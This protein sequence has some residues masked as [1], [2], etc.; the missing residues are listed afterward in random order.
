MPYSYCNWD[1]MQLNRHYQPAPDDTCLLVVSTR[2]Y[3]D[4]LKEF[5]D[6][7]YDTTASLHY[8]A[9]YFRGNAWTAVPYSNLESLL[10]LKPSLRNLVIFTE[11]LGKTYTSGVNRA[12]M[13]MRLYHID[14]IF[15]DWPTQRPYMSRGKNFKTTYQVSGE[16]AKPYATFLGE[17]QRYKDSHAPKFQSITIMFHSMGNLILMHGLRSGLFSNIHPGFAD[18]VILNAACVPQKRHAQWLSKLQF[19]KEIFVTINDRD[20]NL[21]GARLILLRHVMGETTKKP[22]LPGIHYVDFS[23]VLNR[24]HNYYLIIPLLRQKPFLKQFYTDVFSGKMPVLTY[25]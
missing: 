15:F 25:P 8:F 6:Y 18:Q 9:V 7:D 13:L 22:Y 1:N 24:E 11:G 4:S 5:L 14:E 10:D 2:H 19:S 17:F 16:V 20:R 21:R 23:K 12:T 3:H